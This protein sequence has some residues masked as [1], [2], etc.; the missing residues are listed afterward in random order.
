VIRRPAARK[1]MIMDA[2]VLIDFIKAERTVLELVVKHVGPLHLTSLVVD[3]V[4]E[5][6]DENELVELGLVIVEPDIE[7]GCLPPGLGTV[8]S[9]MGAY[10][11][12]ENCGWLPADERPTPTPTR[13]PTC[14]PTQ[15]PT[16]TTTP[17]P[18]DVTGDGI[19]DHDDLFLFAPD[20]KKSADEAAPGCNPIADDAIDEKDLRF[21][22]GAL[23]Q[24]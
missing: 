8:R 10:G 4:N 20:W 14:T 5:I 21:L 6:D 3:E 17:V 1:P 15:T 7:D 13:T 24:E 18:G 2:C 19:V 22:I 23:S 11:G 9:D 12:P 16:P